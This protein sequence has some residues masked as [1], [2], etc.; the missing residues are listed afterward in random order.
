[1]NP[2]NLNAFIHNS[3]SDATYQNLKTFNFDHF[4]QELGNISGRRIN[5]NLYEYVPGVTDFDYKSPDT[6]TKVNEWN[7]VANQFA[8]DIGVTPYQTDRNILVID[9]FIT[10]SVA[11]AAQSGVNAGNSVIA[12]TV[13]AT[14]IAHEVGHTFNAKHTGVMQTPDPANRGNVLSSYMATGDEVGSGSLLRFS[15]INRDRIKSFLGKLE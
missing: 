6:A 1:M 2:I 13:D 9:G 12:S 8:K 14:T 7:T 5:V 3:V 10:G 11:G 4:V 15:T